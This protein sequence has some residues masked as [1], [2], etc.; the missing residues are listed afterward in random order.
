M[1]KK[2]KKQIPG[3]FVP[4]PTKGGGRT[5]KIRQSS[6]KVQKP[7]IETTELGRGRGV[8]R[9]QSHL[10]MEIGKQGGRDQGK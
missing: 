8:T 5:A 9:I 4:C 10:D 3:S 1:E 6:K 7:R 2:T